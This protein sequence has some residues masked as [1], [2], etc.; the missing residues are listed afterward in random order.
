[1]KY[2]NPKNGLEIE[3][4]EYLSFGDVLCEQCGNQI[5]TDT[6]YCPECREFVGGCVVCDVCGGE[7]IVDE[8][9]YSKING[10]TITPPY[11]KVKCENCNGEGRI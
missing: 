5:D 2:I 8:L 3:Y 10:Q 9:D 4:D 6:Y 7:G 11:H 1:M